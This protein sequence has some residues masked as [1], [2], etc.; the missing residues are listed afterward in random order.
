MPIRVTRGLP[1]IKILE[2]EEIFVMDED[3]AM[4]QDIRPLEILILNLM[5]KK[6][7]TETQLL[8]LLSNTPLQMNVNF[9]HMES[10]ETKNTSLEYLER[11]YC[12]FDEIKERFFDGLIITGAPVEQLAFE[13]V[14]YWPE[15]SKVFEWSR[16]HV[17]S[18]FH[19]C[20]GAQA[21]LYYHYGIE[22]YPLLQ[23]C[24]GIFLH[25]VEHANRQ[26]L[27]GFDDQFF[28]PH[29]R[30]TEVRRADIDKEPSLEVLAESQ[31][32]GLFLVGDTVQRNFFAMGHLEYDR[33]TLK[34]EFLR[35]EA[36]GIAPALPV[37]Y[38]PEDDPSKRPM[39]SWHMAA[40]LLFTNWLNYTVYQDTPY[41]LT[42][43]LD[44]T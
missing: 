14:D 10:H 13:E 43:L 36:K 3:R 22:K 1:A 28:A 2:K 24:S 34:E 21:G 19:I 9:L 29:S 16:N 27:R 37:H 18:T 32:A 8:R 30:Y 31:E 38:F 7:E 25:D 6:S 23:K 40:S 35:D 39:L 33:E 11:F 17:F 26:I 42:E 20:W 4:R 41:D 15:L 44:R 12:R 5:P